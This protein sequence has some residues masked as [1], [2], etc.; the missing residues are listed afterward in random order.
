[1]MLS[2]ASSTPI[3]H[4]AQACRKLR[5]P[6]EIVEV[7]V[8]IYRYA[9]LLLERMLV[10]LKAAK[11][12]LG[13]NGPVRTMRSYAGAMVGTFMFSME[14]AEK[15]ESSLACRNYQGYFPV[16]NMPR[17]ISWAWVLVTLAAA[18]AL[19]V[20]GRD[21]VNWNDMAGLLSPLFGW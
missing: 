18:A 6:K 11:C 12:R 8:L 21:L 10:M 14:L 17:N 9:F 20:F 16:Y 3:P 13:Y 1:M 15:S 19:F 4:L 7:V 2:F 5:M